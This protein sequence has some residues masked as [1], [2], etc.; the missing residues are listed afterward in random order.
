MWIHV[1]LL[2]LLPVVLGAEFIFAAFALAL[3]TVLDEEVDADADGNNDDDR[4]NDDF[5]DDLADTHIGR[6]CVVGVEVRKEE[7]GW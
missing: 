6:I 3:T 1:L 4:D 5:S 2:V 7:R